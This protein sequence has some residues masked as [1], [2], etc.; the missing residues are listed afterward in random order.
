MQEWCR[1]FYINGLKDLNPTFASSHPHISF[2]DFAKPLFYTL[3][4]VLMQ[5]ASFVLLISL[6]SKGFGI[7]FD[8]NLCSW[9][10]RWIRR[11]LDACYF[12][13]FN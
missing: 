5:L 7:I 13:D 2:G 10:V 8:L 4:S 1:S 6:V 9:I 3:I 11:H 12:I